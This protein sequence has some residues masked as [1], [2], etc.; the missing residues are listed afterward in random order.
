MTVRTYRIVVDGELSEPPLLGIDGLVLS[1]TGGTTTL[2]VRIRDHA[3]L[4]GILQLVRDLG[5]TLFE[6][7]AAADE[8]G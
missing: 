6:T 8:S 2:T 1:R 5:L 3:E 4:H 7:A